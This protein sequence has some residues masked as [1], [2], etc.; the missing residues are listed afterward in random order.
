MPPKEFDLVYSFSTFFLAQQRRCEFSDSKLPIGVAT[1]A[2]GIIMFSPG[3]VNDRVETK[4]AIPLG[5]PNNMKAVSP[6]LLFLCSGM[7]LCWIRAPC[8]ETSAGVTFQRK[9]VF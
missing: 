8:S 9:A 6:T 2:G 4:A 1:T 5:G 7:K 3:H